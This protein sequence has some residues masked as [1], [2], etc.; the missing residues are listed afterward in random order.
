MRVGEQSFHLLLDVPLLL[1]EELVGAVLPLFGQGD[2]LL[3][4]LLVGCVHGG[5]LGGR[6]GAAGRRR[7]AAGAGSPPGPPER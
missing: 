4:D 2:G 1:G 6:Q 5:S 3:D 7:M